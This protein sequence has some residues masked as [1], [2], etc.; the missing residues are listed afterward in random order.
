IDVGAPEFLCFEPDCIQR[1]CVFA[2][3]VREGVGEYVAAMTRCD[4]TDSSSHVPREPSVPGNL[5]VACTYPGTEVKS[6]LCSNI[7]AIGRH[8]ASYQTLDHFGARRRMGQRRH[9]GGSSS[10]DLLIRHVAEI[11]CHG[12]NRGN[13][14]LI[15]ARGQIL[16]GIHALYGMPRTINR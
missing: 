3:I 9:V 5:D 15:V 10:V 14:M 2:L 13:P 4:H 1:L 11:L 16:E 12:K 6:R 8:A 7:V